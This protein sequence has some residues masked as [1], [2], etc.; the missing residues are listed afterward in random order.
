VNCGDSGGTVT[1]CSHESCVKVVNKSNLETKSQSRVTHS[2]RAR[3]VRDFAL[4]RIYYSSETCASAECASAVNVVCRDADVFRT[5][6]VSL[7]HI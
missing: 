7:S 2:P 5:K 1:K 6:T 4:F 3:Y